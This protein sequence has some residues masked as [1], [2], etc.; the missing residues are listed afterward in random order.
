MALTALQVKNAKP[1]S[2][3]SDGGGLRL[4][5]DGNG[6]KYWVFRYTSP[7]TGKGRQM[8]IAP[9]GDMTLAAARDAAGEARSLIRKGIDPIDAKHEKRTAARVD[10]SRGITFE[11]FAEQV[12]SGK[13]AGWQNAKHRQ[14]WR[15]TLRDYA[16][17]HIGHLP[18]ADVDTEAVLRVLR[19][20]WTVKPETARRVRARIEAIL[21][22]AKVKGLRVGENPA[23]WRSHLA[24]SEL[25]RHKKSDDQHHAALDYTDMPRFWRS[26]A[27]DSSDAARMARFVILTA[28]RYG[29]AKGIAAGE[30]RGDVWTVPASRMKTRR[31]PHTVPLTRL[32]LA[33]LPF[34]PV[35]DVTLARCIARHARE[36]VTTH[37]FRS[38]FRDWAGD[39][40]HFPRE[41]CE[42]A[43]AH[44]VGNAT[45]AAY[46][47]NTAMQKRRNLMEEWAKYCSSMA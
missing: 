8:G 27:K 20:I 16:F 28:V 9:A 36:K 34:R 40:T 39:M 23:L 46:R 19:P 30:V 35:S 24:E 47:R 18:I 26:L 13:E 6:N 31:R 2:K 45:E 42:S 44:A 25:A 33:Q 7:V 37:G 3:L 32:A 15:N 22:A 41:V 1:N 17:P 5:V 43:L 4:D 21:S 38:T 29:E 11:A 14:Q 12:I 10:A